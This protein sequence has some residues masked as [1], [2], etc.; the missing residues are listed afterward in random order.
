MGFPPSS[1]RSASFCCVIINRWHNTDL[2]AASARKTRALAGLPRSRLLP[3]R[4]DA[5]DAR[6]GQSSAPRLVKGVCCCCD[7]GCGFCHQ[8][9]IHFAVCGKP[10][11]RCYLQICIIKGAK[12][13]KMKKK[14]RFQDNCGVRVLPQSH[15]FKG[16]V[17]LVV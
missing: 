13:K 14:N 11:C 15:A 10:S 6:P 1:P 16:P 2:A 17:C 5:T 3:S 9:P 12:K 7:G 4:A 8:P